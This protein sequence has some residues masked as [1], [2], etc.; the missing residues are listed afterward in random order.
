MLKKIRLAFYDKND[1]MKNFV[2]F[3][4]RQKYH[5]LETRLFTSFENLISQA[6][7]GEVDVLLAGEDAQEEI[8]ILHSLVPQIILLSEGNVV[9]EDSTFC[10][11]FKYQSVPDIM[12]EVLAVVA[13]N[14][15]IVYTEKRTMHKTAEMLAVYAPFGGSGV[16]QYAFSMAKDLSDKFRTLYVNLEAFYGFSEI[17]T[18]KKGKP[19]EDFRGMSEVIFYIRQKKEKLALKLESIIVTYQN[20]DCLLTVEDY[21][22]LF[23][24]TKDDMDRLIQV[25]LWETDY[26]KIIFDIGFITD[27][28]MVLFEKA[29][30][31]FMPQAKHPIQKSKQ[32]AFERLI[33]R[34][35]LEKIW[36]K[37]DKVSVLHRYQVSEER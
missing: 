37:T 8:T 13:D 24:M 32:Q 23:Y 10:K 36:D 27:A 5:T 34:E 9:R 18:D 20:L 33:L 19:I 35:H 16:S 2:Q 31:I 15:S 30:R 7:K 4:S 1:Y 28:M 6:K 29:D 21:R 11:I 17:V 26:E 25:L 3:L 14:D 12:R 22:D